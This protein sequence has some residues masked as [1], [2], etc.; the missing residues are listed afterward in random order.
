MKHCH[1]SILYNELP[2]LKQKLPFLYDNFDQVIFYDLNVCTHQP[3][4][5]TDGCHEFIKDFPDRDWETSA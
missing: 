1:F 4:F 5:S 2:F 3:H